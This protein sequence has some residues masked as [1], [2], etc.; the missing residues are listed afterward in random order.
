MIRSSFACERSW[1][2]S[3]TASATTHHYSVIISFK[4]SD[5]FISFS[6]PFIHLC[7]YYYSC[8]TSSA[9]SA[10]RSMNVPEQPTT[11]KGES[12]SLLTPHALLHHQSH[13]SA[14]TSA[15]RDI[16]TTIPAHRHFHFSFAFY[17]SS[18]SSFPSL[19]S[20]PQQCG[21]RSACFWRPSR[22]YYHYHYRTAPAPAPAP[23]PQLHL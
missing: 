10:L 6:K 21:H 2:V 22:Y 3:G 23:A 9:L 13:L 14:S 1:V 12:T 18:V 11:T 19:P 17:V 20:P 15:R 4:C 5:H 7:L 16:T 8:S